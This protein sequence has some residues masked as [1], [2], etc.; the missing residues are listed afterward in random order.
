M[1]TL[2]LHQW[3]EAQR[4]TFWQ[5]SIALNI[6]LGIIGLYLLLNALALGYFADEIL[7]EIYKDSD[8]IDSFNRILFY[9]FSIDIIMRFLFQPLPILSIQAYLSLPIKKSNLLHYPL[10]KSVFNFINLLALLLT[11]PFF[12]K[13]ICNTQS[14]IYC[15][16]WLLVVIAFIAA[17][18]F[19]NFFLKKYFVKKPA[20][21]FLVLGF[22]GA[23]IYSDIANLISFSSLFSE[24][25]SHLN[26]QPIL[27]LIP[28]AIAI[29]SYFN[30]YH[31]LKRNSYIEDLINPKKRK[32]SS[33]SFLNRYGETGDLLG[34]ELKMALR[35]KRPRSLLLLGTIFLLYGFIFYKEESLNDYYILIIA[36]VLLTAAAAFN[37]AQLMF[38]WN[39]SFFD[40]LLSNKISME[41][42]IKSKFIFFALICVACYF[43]ILPYAFISY[44]IAFINTAIL[45]YNI[46]ITFFLLAYS[47]T[48]STSRID[49]GKGIFMNYEGMGVSQFLIIIPLFAIP[50]LFQFVFSSIGYPHYGIYIL[51]IIGLLA[52]TC[53]KFLIRLIVSQLEKRKYKMAVGFR[54]K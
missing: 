16:A 12:L 24:L 51:G 45:F 27:L 5:K 53:N 33:F 10:V 31:L 17:N 23:L 54:Q 46:G 35:N 52:M 18:N 44:K 47:S 2:L 26:S 4:S 21:I 38:A 36:G 20:L 25:F 22:V 34:I 32:I 29:G 15:F 8:T 49:M 11:I 48:F 41:N 1:I 9:F 19:T 42:Y 7:Q 40:S 28:L 50:A 3:K 43:I 30:A 6:L 13:V 37:H 14:S 39:S